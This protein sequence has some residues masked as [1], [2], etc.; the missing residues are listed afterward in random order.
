MLPGTWSIISGSFGGSSWLGLYELG[1]LGTSH[2]TV[3]YLKSI[4]PLFC[5]L[6]YHKCW[7][8]HTENAHQRPSFTA[9]LTFWIDWR[10]TLGIGIL[11]DGLFGTGNGSSV[12]VENA[13]LLALTRVG[14]RRVVQ[15]SAGFM[16]FFS[17]LVPQYFN[18]YTSVLLVWSLCTHVQ[19]GH[20]KP[21]L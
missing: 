7:E 5:S 12:S 19:D 14:S 6:H 18:E 3:T 17:I 2:P 15:I 11:L 4:L 8:E 9:E 21:L 13:G 20:S 1:F 16:I 10:R